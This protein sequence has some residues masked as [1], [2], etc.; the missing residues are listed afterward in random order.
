M[1]SV[2]LASS[3]ELGIP[4]FAYNLGSGI[5][6]QRITTLVAAINTAEKAT[7]SLANENNTLTI[8]SMLLGIRTSV[9][10]F[11]NMVVLIVFIIVSAA[12][13]IYVLVSLHTVKKL[14]KQREEDTLGE[15]KF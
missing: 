5:V 11:V 1:D 15:L 12:L 3:K 8:Q 6:K 4:N 13:G 14:K 7:V 2:M 9:M 10:N